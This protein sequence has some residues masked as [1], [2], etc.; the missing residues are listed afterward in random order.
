[1]FDTDSSSYTERPFF[2]TYLSR[3]VKCV[4]RY[5]PKQTNTGCFEKNVLSYYYNLHT[6]NNSWSGTNTEALSDIVTSDI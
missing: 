2:L 4:D 1:M 3:E 5:R 6:S